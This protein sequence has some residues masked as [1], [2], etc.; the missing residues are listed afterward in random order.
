MMNWCDHRLGLQPAADMMQASLAPAEAKLATLPLCDLVR[1]WR[2]VGTV[3]LREQTPG[4]H[5]FDMYFDRLGHDDPV[6]ALAFIEAEVAAEPNDALVALVADGKLLS[7]LLHYNAARVVDGLEAAV[8]RLPRLR[9]LLGAI[10]WT[11][12]SGMVADEAVV[13]RLRAIADEAAYKG[14]EIRHKAGQEMI[15]FAA[16]PLGEA[17]RLWVRITA[18]CPLERAR[19]DNTSALFD[20]QWD[21][22]R[23]EPQRA[24]ALVREI[25]RIEDHPLLLSVL[26]AGLLE[27]LLVA[28]GNVLISAIEIEAR[29]NWRFRQVLGGVW[30][31]SVDPKVVK[32]LER[33]IAVI[34]S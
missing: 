1:G 6:R 20:F 2:E 22:A 29:R 7:Q 8:A 17:A 27:D 32:R 11:F 9:W 31:S 24:L 16:L 28:H 21:L 15:N 13:R 14:W 3:G 4:T 12:R 34:A 5:C 26:G 18:Y 30:T 19:D 23:D 10:V 25:V 33:A